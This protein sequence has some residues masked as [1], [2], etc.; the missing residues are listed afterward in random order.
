M[1]LGVGF[2]F[3]NFVSQKV[4]KVVTLEMLLLIYLKN[5]N[6]RT[7][8]FFSRSNHISLQ[9]H[10]IIK[11]GRRALLR[12]GRLDLT[13]LTDINNSLL[14]Y[15]MA[16]LVHLNVLAIA[17]KVRLAADRAG[18]VLKKYGKMDLSESSPEA[19]EGET[20]NEAKE[21]KL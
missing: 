8:A 7:H 17:M 1:G 13:V 11:P 5:T 21:G 14:W 18:T 12:V 2:F 15:R 3:Q 16:T 20:Y 6:G 4:N 19:A 9:E 10:V